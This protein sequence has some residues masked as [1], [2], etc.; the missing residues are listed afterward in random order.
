VECFHAEDNHCV[1]TR[2][3]GLRGVLADALQA[4]FDVLDR[5]TLQDLVAQPEPL[6]RLL[7]GG[8]PVTLMRK[9]AV[10]GPLGQ[11]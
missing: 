3:C 6:T 9:P 2:V 11:G 7:S 1:I 5:Y 4:Y 8:V 10:S